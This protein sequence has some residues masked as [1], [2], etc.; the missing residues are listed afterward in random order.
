[1]VSKGLSLF[2]VGLGGG[3][4]LSPSFVLGLAQGS[5]DSHLNEI[6]FITV[7]LL[8]VIAVC[9]VVLWFVDLKSK[10]RGSYRSTHHVHL[11]RNG[12]DAAY[13]KLGT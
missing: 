3:I 11:V 12:L 5:G 8:V 1:M 9:L 6:L 2:F 7:L 4:P 13:F 10:G